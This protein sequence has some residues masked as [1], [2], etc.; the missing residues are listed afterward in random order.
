MDPVEAQKTRPGA[1]PGPFENQHQKKHNFYIHFLSIG[2]CLFFPG[3]Q[4][5]GEME[6]SRRRQFSLSRP[7]LERLRSVSSFLR[8]APG[9]LQ[10]PLLSSWRCPA[11]SQEGPGASND[12]MKFTK[13]TCSKPWKYVYLTLWDLKKSVPDHF[14]TLLGP[15][16]DP[17]ES[18][19][20][21]SRSPLGTQKG[22]LM[23]SGTPHGPSGAPFWQVF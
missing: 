8:T 9:P 4:H 7:S 13:L 6:H 16:R 21:P 1:L 2:K 17:P 23:R 10:S 11:Y 20:F 22:L 14:F 3:F 15:T 12:H 5:I 19:P 18:S